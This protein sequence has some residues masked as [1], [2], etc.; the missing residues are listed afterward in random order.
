MG[1]GRLVAHRDRLKQLISVGPL[2]DWTNARGR[3]QVGDY[4]RM[5][6]QRFTA[7][8]ATGKPTDT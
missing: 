6:D 4:D 3:R 2:I 8:L 5:G 1:E 7:V